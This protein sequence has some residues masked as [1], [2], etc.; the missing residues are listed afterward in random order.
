MGQVVSRA[1]SGTALST[2][3][4]GPAPECPANADTAPVHPELRA[5]ADRQL[6]VFT[7]EDARR[8]GYRLDEVRSRLKSREWTRLRR[9]IYIETRR[10]AELRADSRTA[11]LLDCVAV[12]VA[13]GDA[14]VLSHESAARLHRLELPGS[15]SDIVR[16]SDEIQWREGR[17]YRV[18]RATL[19]GADLE[20]FE[21]FRVT[22]PARTLVDCAREWS[23]VDAVVAMDAALHGRM[24]SRV[25]LEA[26]VHFARHWVGVGN[27]GRALSFAD[28]RAESGLESR[29][30]LRL[31]G[32]GFPTP[33][34]QVELH[35]ARGFIGR[36]DAWYEEAAVAI[37]FDGRVK[38]SDPTKGRSPTDVLWDEKRRE[39]AIRGLDV[40]VLRVVNADLGSRWSVLTERLRGML[41]VPMVGP[42]RF[43]V[44][45]CREPGDDASAA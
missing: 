24:V 5:T 27:A 33:E 28:G 29:G 7:A 30:R 38:Y 3:S 31:L 13:L 42:R 22:S 16:L 40:R 4:A 10:A 26:A 18:A 21:R 14:P 25:Q 17:G 20:R 12:L 43:T 19:P 15:A 32:S 44:V 8:A 23:L 36:V 2:T 9:G 37:E 45:R 35:D 6:G 1:R 11:H 34:L 39:D 41:A